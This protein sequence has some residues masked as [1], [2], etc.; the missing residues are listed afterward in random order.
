MQKVN[1]TKTLTEIFIFKAFDTEQLQEIETI[2]TICNTKKNETIFSEGEE[3]EKFFAIVSGNFKVYKMSPE[4]KEQTI[5]ILKK[6]DLIAEAAIFDKQTYPASCQSLGAGTLIQVSKL[7]FIKFLTT[8]PATSLKLLGLY[9]KKLRQLVSLIEDLSLNDVKRR[10]AKYLITN[11]SH[12]ANG[13]ECKL[14]ISKKELAS[15]L[16][17]T[18][19]SLS[20]AI[21]IFKKSK[22]II[23]SA[24]KF[25]I[26]NY[27]KLESDIL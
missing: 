24:E 3:A 26:I 6:G 14:S 21:N 27:S 12:T 17:T 1:I 11:S 4:G 19:E 8:N 16:G 15:L 18:P 7:E 5:H 20:R 9:S 23:E 10:F 22:L 25:Q 13:Y 2:S